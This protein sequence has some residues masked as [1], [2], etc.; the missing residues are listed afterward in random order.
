MSL[1][2][3]FSSLKNGIAGFRAV[4]NYGTIV[5]PGVSWALRL[6]TPNAPFPGARPF[7][8]NA[9]K[10]IVAITDGEQTTEAFFSGRAGD[11]LC[12]SATNTVSPFAYTPANNKI[13]GKPL[14][15]DGPLDIFSAYGYIYD[16][17]PFNRNYSS[18][19]QVDPSLDDLLLS[20]CDYAKQ[21]PG[22]EI[23]T[24]AVS[25]AAGPGTRV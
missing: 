8:A 1:T 25:S 6:L 13:S 17:D 12:K 7:S 19:G 15:G 23:Y 2:T 16:S 20:A 4:G 24:V 10:V 5:A 9:R 18:I 14:N 21:K 3:D 11:T 22:V